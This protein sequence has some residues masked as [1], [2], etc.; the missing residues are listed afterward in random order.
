MEPSGAVE[1]LHALAHP[2][3]L[4]VVKLLIESGPGGLPAGQVAGTLGTPANSMSAQL[5]ILSRAKL[6]SSERQGRSIIY[7]ARYDR[8][9]ELLTF[10]LEDCC[11]GSPRIYEPLADLINGASAADRQMSGPHKETS[12]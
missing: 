6:I 1:L 5:A 7:A 11:S 4:A 3:R 2:G 10:L 8:M 12:S 9:T